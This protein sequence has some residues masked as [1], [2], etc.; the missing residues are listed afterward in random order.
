MCVFSFFLV[1]GRVG[2]VREGGG[3]AP[4]VRQSGPAADRRPVPRHFGTS[5]QRSGGQLLT[6]T[7]THTLREASFT[8]L[9]F[10][11]TKG[12]G[13]PIKTL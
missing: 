4:G 5:R 2:A 13:S 9:I 11:D 8:R 1:G 6:L 3:G 12:G 7:H 10:T